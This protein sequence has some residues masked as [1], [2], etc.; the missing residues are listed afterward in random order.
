LRCYTPS[1]IL[2]IQGQGKDTKMTTTR[3]EMF[4]L[5]NLKMRD[6]GDAIAWKADITLNG[7]KVGWVDDDGDNMF[8]SSAF[9]DLDIETKFKSWSLENGLTDWLEI[10]VVSAGLYKLS[11]IY[12]VEVEGFVL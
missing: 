5:K 2:V 12:A 10:D 7:K 11:E 8:P 1:H 3:K 6:T 9:N 4:R